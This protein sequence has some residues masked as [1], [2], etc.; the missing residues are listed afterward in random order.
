M[1]KLLGLGLL[2]F[3]LLLVGLGRQLFL[4]KLV[5]VVV[6]GLTFLII[7]LIKNKIAFPKY[8]RLWLVF[9]LILSLSFFWTKNTV[10]SF[11]EWLLFLAGTGFWVIGFNLKKELRKHLWLILIS[12]GLVFGGIWGYFQWVRGDLPVVPFSLWGHYSNYKNHLMLGDYWSGV[13]GIL[14]VK[15][16]KKPRSVFLW[17]LLSLGGYFVIIS[18]SRAALVGLMVGVGYLASKNQFIKE[19]VF[20]WIGIGLVCMFFWMAMTKSTLLVR[21]LFTNFSWFKRLSFWS[22]FK[23]LWIDF[24]KC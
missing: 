11:E 20:K 15:L 3:S 16:I 8:F 23:K 13:L 9:L 12:L 17:M 7:K 6:T 5:G 18:Q 1:I 10:A 21:L 4:V 2:G 22:W 19:K 24:R 14:L